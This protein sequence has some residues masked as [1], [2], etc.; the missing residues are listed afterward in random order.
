MNIVKN[1]KLMLLLLSLLSCNVCA[2]DD[3]D[4]QID[5][6]SGVEALGSGNGLDGLSSLSTDL[7]YPNDSS[8]NSPKSSSSVDTRK[9]GKDYCV[10]RYHL[11]PEMKQ[12]LTA[13]ARRAK[14]KS[15]KNE[16]SFSVDGEQAEFLLRYP[17][18]GDLEKLEKQAALG[19]TFERVGPAD[20]Q[21]LQ[22]L[23]E[24]VSQYTSKTSEELLSEKKMAEVGRLFDEDDP[25]KAKELAEVLRAL[26]SD[27]SPEQLKRL[28]DL[29]RKSIE[30]PESRFRDP[31]E[32]FA[33]YQAMGLKYEVDRRNESVWERLNSTDVKVGVI[34]TVGA[35]AFE[36]LVQT[37]GPPIFDVIAQ[38]LGMGPS[39]QEKQLMMMQEQNKA[40]LRQKLI[41]ADLNKKEM[42][43]SILRAI[44]QKHALELKKE[45]LQM[46]SVEKS[47]E[48]WNNIVELTRQE[49]HQ[50]ANFSASDK[51]KLEGLKALYKE[52]QMIHQKLQD[53]K[54]PVPSGVTIPGVA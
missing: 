31:K 47:N 7:G 46:E 39:E 29:G 3:G 40:V 38:K 36:F 6:D 27:K 51:K 18:P 45:E 42:E 43:V 22:K 41:F 19:R 10:N 48:L 50:G 1:Q 21:K 26:S 20:T 13:S 23:Q 30:A 24:L 32:L 5:D 33:Y 15:P 11:P 9:K 53:L 44:A 49:L 8:T 37:F 2:M 34:L 17:M 28:V 52:G 16:S 35:T 12:A 14:E 25:N 54:K 4:Q